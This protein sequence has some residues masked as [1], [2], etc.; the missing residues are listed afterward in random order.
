MIRGQIK[1][2]GAGAVLLMLAAWLFAEPP[3]SIAPQ[4]GVL[5]LRNGRVISGRVALDGQRYYVA[6]PGGELRIRA[7]DVQFFCKDLEEGY[8]K[9]RAALDPYNVNDR[10]DLAQWCLTHGLLGPAARELADAMA[11]EPRHPRIALLERRLQA[12]REPA[13]QAPSAAAQPAPPAAAPREAPPAQSRPGE[14][15]DR[16]TRDL[17]KGVVENFTATIQPML[18][19]RCGNA[20]CHGTT[21]VS[22]FRLER[23]PIHRIASQR[24]TQRNLQAVLQTVDRQSPDDSPLLRKALEAHGGAKAPPFAE[25]DAVQLRQLAAWLGQLGSARLSE[26]TLPSVSGQQPPLLQPMPGVETAAGAGPDSAGSARVHPQR[27]ADQPRPAADQP[28][29]VI[30]P[31]AQ[32]PA[33]DPFDPQAFNQRYFPQGSG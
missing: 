20:A 22:S 33:S 23:V 18:Q 13:P 7:E 21:T 12:L 19:N 28:R 9:R 26:Q 17:P 27:A 8:R 16:L 24:L 4:E 30:L 5:L 29:R 6:V 15:L 31:A 3:L 25:R 11:V 32:A 10:L 14:D 1:L 2:F